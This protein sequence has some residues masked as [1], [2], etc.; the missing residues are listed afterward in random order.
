MRRALT[1]KAIAINGASS[2]TRRLALINTP[3]VTRG[4]ACLSRLGFLGFDLAEQVGLEG[5][6]A[7]AL[8][9]RREGLGLD[10]G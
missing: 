8:I 9:R 3:V 1:A 6:Q 4:P 7:L 5:R 10:R 2:S